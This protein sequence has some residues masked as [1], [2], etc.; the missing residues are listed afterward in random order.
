MMQ[1]MIRTVTITDT[2]RMMIQILKQ[3][4][5]LVGEAEAMAGVIVAAMKTQE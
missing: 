1:T 4:V 3:S 2:M 5:V